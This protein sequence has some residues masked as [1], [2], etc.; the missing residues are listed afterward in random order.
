MTLFANEH[1]IAFAVIATPVITTIC[2]IV[3]IVVREIMDRF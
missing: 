1:P 2:C 3:L